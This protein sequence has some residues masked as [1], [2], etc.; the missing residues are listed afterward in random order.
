MNTESYHDSSEYFAAPGDNHGAGPATGWL[1]ELKLL[2]AMAAQCFVT[3][4]LFTIILLAL[5]AALDK[6]ALAATVEQNIESLSY[7]Q[8]I[9]DDCRSIKDCR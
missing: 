6:V 1:A 5:A 4:L 8:R 9:A 2:L 7:E 3:T